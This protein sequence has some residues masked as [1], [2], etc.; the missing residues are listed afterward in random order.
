M[1]YANIH[2]AV[3]FDEEN[4]VVEE[5]IE[6]PFCRELRITMYAHQVMRD[7]ESDHPLMIEVCEGAVTLA[8]EAGERVLPRGC[9][10]AVEGGMKHHIEALQDS[11]LRLTLLTDCGN[12]SDA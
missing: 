10:V 11:I 3:V 6:T 4:V 8:S 1:K 7:H 2:E 5:L 9:I 12:G